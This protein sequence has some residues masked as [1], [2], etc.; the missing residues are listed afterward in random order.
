[1]VYDIRRTR[2][3]GC[4]SLKNSA[5]VVVVVVLIVVAAVAGGTYLLLRGPSTGTL[6][7]GV[8]DAPVGSN[9]THIYLTISSIVLQSSD[10]ATTTF[11]VNAT[12]FDLLSFVDVTEMLG[13]DSIPAANYTMIRF[14][15]TGAQAT[16]SGVNVTLTVPSQEVKVPI[17]F[18]V[19]ANKTTTVVLDITVDTTNI[20]AAHNLRPVVLVK[21]VTGP[22]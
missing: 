22:S 6:A 8:T 20:S 14:N 19:Q 2:Y 15:V 13:S 9:V 17:H 10:N 3:P 18:E 5:V 1:M 12:Q 4:R 11:K 7:I 21:S 16:I